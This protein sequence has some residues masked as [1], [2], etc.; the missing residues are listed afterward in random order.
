MSKIDVK[1]SNCGE[2]VQLDDRRTEGFCN[3]CGSKLIIKDLTMDNS[4]Y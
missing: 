3:Y 4:K 2:T 1:C